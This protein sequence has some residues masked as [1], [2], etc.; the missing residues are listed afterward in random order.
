[1]PAH[2]NSV[3]SGLWGLYNGP[4]ALLQQAACLRQPAYGECD[5]QH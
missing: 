5:P 4:L 2:T 1:M 3:R